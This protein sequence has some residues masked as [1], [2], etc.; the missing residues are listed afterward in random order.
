MTSRQPAAVIFG[1]LL[2][3]EAGGC[4][5]KP[6]PPPVVAPPPPRDFW[7]EAQ[8]AHQQ[9]NYAE[10]Y[11]FARNVP[12]DHPNAA[13]AAQLAEQLSPKVEKLQARLLQKA[14]DAVLLGFANRAI[15]IYSEI[16]KG[17]ALQP[18][19]KQD[20]EKKLQAAKEQLQKLKAEFENKLRTAKESLIRGDAFDAYRAFSRASDIADDQGFQWTFVEEQQLELAKSELPEGKKSAAVRHASR[21][22]RRA[23]SAQPQEAE[24]IIGSVD[25]FATQEQEISRLKSVRDL[26]ERARDYRKK[27]MLYEA[28]VAL[29]E[30]KRKDSDSAAVK[31]LIDEL[32]DERAR[33][34][35][36]YLEIADRFFAKQD[37]EAAVPYFKRVRK[38]DPDNIRANEAIQMYQNLERIK[39]ERGGDARK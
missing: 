10:A 2:L 24:A 22:K 18:E 6:A 14:D 21:K 20:L 39:Q 34:I 29:E 12:A 13:A 17:Y 11:A 37:L 36:E 28:L 19:R 1:L 25:T 23:T 5:P 3:F 8:H 4:A 16:L 27:G 32:D 30:A 26:V 7:V 31:L 33:L 35:D 38:L 9:A 15:L